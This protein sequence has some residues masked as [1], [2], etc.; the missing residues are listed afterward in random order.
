MKSASS[1]GWWMAI[2]WSWFSSK[3]GSV[4]T[5]LNGSMF[6]LWMAKKEKSHEETKA[7]T[8]AQADANEAE[9][10]LKEAA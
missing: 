3:S 4:L 6:Q 5:L 7:K 8:V 10:V 1:S 9:A 2:M